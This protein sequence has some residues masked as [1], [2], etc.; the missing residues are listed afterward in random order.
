[1]G[2][3][4]FAGALFS[5]LGRASAAAVAEWFG[6]WSPRA[7]PKQRDWI[8]T[9]RFEIP[10]GTLVYGFIPVRYEDSGVYERIKR[11][12]D[13]AGVV[14]TLAGARAEGRLLSDGKEVAVILDEAGDWELAWWVDGDRVFRTRWFKENCPAPERF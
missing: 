5:E 14:A 10:D 6:Q 11:G 1:W 7:K 8:V 13:S 12:L 9:L 4:K 3:S 2:A